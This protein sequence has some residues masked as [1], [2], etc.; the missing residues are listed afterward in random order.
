MNPHPRPLP[1]SSSAAQPCSVET[2]RRLDAAC[3]Q[4]EAAWTSGREPRIQ[5]YL[6]LFRAEEHPALLKAL[7]DL[8]RELIVRQAARLEQREAAAGRAHARTS[9]A[10]ASDSEVTARRG[11]DPGRL[12]AQ[13]KGDHSANPAPSTP[14]V[15]LSPLAVGEE[16]DATAVWN[17]S[18]VKISV[19]SG[20]HAGITFESGQHS[21]LVV[22][23][24]EQAQLRLK[25]DPNISRHHMRFEINPPQCYVMDLGSVNGVRVNGER[26]Q[27]AF[28]RHGDVIGAG[29]NTRLE[30]S[31]STVHP[32]A[33]PSV[34]SQPRKRTEAARPGN[35]APVR[36]DSPAPAGSRPDTSHGVS[37]PSA[38]P[39][40]GTRA[41]TLV[42]PGYHLS[43]P[44]A[45]T[46]QGSLYDA[47]QI[48]SGKPCLIKVLPTVSDGGGG[49]V[50]PG[51]LSR[52]RA[53]RA[54]LRE[55]EV[56]KQLTHPNV[57]RLLDVGEVSGML[58]FVTE[59]FAPLD[60]SELAKN[61]TPDTRIRVACGLMRQ[62]LSALQYAHAR[63]FIHRDVKPANVLLTR[64]DGK[65][66]AKLADFG[67]AKRYTDAGLSHMTRDG[68]VI[69]SLQFMA[70][71]QF[72]NSR[73]ATPA[74]DIYSAGATLYWMLTGQ[75]P[76]P[77]DGH[78]CKFLAILEQAPVPLRSRLPAA[79][80]SVATII[81]RAL[82]KDPLRRFRSAD[83]FQFQLKSALAG[84]SE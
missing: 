30:V 20:P 54:F 29:K 9:P 14:T 25:D 49:G 40:S 2:L 3:D 52:E 83:E 43:G 24:S 33:P 84:G 73:E 26:V 76:I 81:H 51:G 6:A 63:S 35:A 55:V 13:S 27:G 46:E 7:Q 11:A 42:I 80:D 34:P 22:G 53:T 65:L 17:G 36:D 37:G 61:Y 12:T 47:V 69:G 74:C 60:W 4:F 31:I 32:V 59:Q 10:V 71:E 67:V 64:V 38:P 56:L 18:S 79:S 78:S 45:E 48:A 8:E 23:R 41:A 15:T 70:P 68:D 21:T 82:D 19:I 72:I 5:D 1:P 28:V 16:D 44:K 50:A 77:L 62:V 75:E 58:Y 57:V 39:E 66:R